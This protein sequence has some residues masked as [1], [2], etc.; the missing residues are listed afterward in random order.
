MTRRSCRARLRVQSD[1]RRCDLPHSDTCDLRHS[2]WPARPARVSD[3]RTTA[4]AAAV[5]VAWVHQGF[6]NGYYIPY[7]GLIFGLWLLYYSSTRQTMRRAWGIIVAWAIS[8]LALVPMLLKC[9]RRCTSSWACTVPSTRFSTSVPAR[10]PG[11]KSAT[12]SRCGRACSRRAKTTS[13]PGSSLS[14]SSPQVW[15][16]IHDARVERHQR[17]CSSSRACRVVAAGCGECREHRGEP[18]GG[19]RRYDAWSPP[20]KIRNLNRGLLVLLLA[21]AP[22]AWSSAA[23]RRAWTPPV[24]SV[25][26]P[27]HRGLRGAGLRSDS[28]G[29]RAPD[30]RSCAVWPFDGAPGFNELRVPTQIKMIHLLGL[31]VAAA[32]A[33]ARL[34]SPRSAIRTAACAVL[35]AGLVAEGWLGAMPLDA[36]VP[37]WSG[38]SLQTAPSHCSNC[39]WGQATTARRRWAAIHHRRVMNGVSGYD[40]PHTWR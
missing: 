33:Y 18:V 30:P 13:F 27:L 22:L 4:V 2:V 24:T 36:A 8:S 12:S 16:P 25:L 17:A 37:S 39:P 40:P 1:A 32:I 7:G 3:E 35:A 19:S 10:S 6:A 29:A 34:L 14:R 5:R 31:C 28:A 23:L 9:P 26:Y 15:S 38:W 20:V 11:S 21:G